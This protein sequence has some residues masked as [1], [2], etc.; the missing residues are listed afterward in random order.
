VARW[1]KLVPMLRC[2]LLESHQNRHGF[3]L[4][5][6]AGFALIELLVVTLV[7]GTLLGI[8]IPLYLSSVRHASVQSVKANL[9]SSP[10]GPFV[11]KTVEN[12]RE[13]FGS[14]GTGDRATYI[15]SSNTYVGLP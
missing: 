13:V 9:S 15:L 10:G 8:A 4:E 1:V 6:P 7:I 12:G 11:V 5:T 14:L 3:V 2:R